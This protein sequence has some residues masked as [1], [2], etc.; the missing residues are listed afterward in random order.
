MEVLRNMSAAE[1]AHYADPQLVDLYDLLNAG[2]WD[3]AFY[4]ARIG[5]QPR[6]ILDLG[7][8]TGTLALRLAADGHRVVAIDPSSAMLDYA[9]QRPGS[10][11]VHWIAADVQR[12]PGDLRF[13]VVTMTGHAFQH[14]LTHDEVM[15]T[16]QAARERLVTGGSFMFETRNPVVR[17]WIAWTP[18]LTAR[19]IQSEAHGAVDVFH[20]CV[21]VTGPLVEFE[22]HYVFHRENAHRK[23][24]SKLRF[25]TR[26]EVAD[27]TRQAGFSD[28]EWFG[29]WNGGPFL[30]TTSTEIIAI[31]RA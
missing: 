30:E 4:Q 15:A 27:A 7:C 9:R 28:V 1:N 29:D 26:E 31:C 22:T 16:L 5:K 14:L 12:V 18:A 8:G 17:P 13:D 2:D 10:D 11:E 25:M 24:T 6:R 21:A 3:Y 20:E 23:S 19:S